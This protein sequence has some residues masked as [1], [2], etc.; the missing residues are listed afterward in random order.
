MSSQCQTF[1]FK[2]L[3]PEKLLHFCS[4]YSL[5]NAVLCKPCFIYL[6]RQSQPCNSYPCVSVALVLYHGAQGHRKKSFPTLQCE[7]QSSPQG[8]T[9]GSWVSLTK[10]LQTIDSSH[11]PARVQAG[12]QE[13]RKKFL[14]NQWFVFAIFL[15]KGWDACPTGSSPGSSGVTTGMLMVVSVLGPFLAL[16]TFLSL[17][18]DLCSPPLPLGDSKE[19]TWSGTKW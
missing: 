2:K 14:E 11:R 9:G 13:G 1:C 18:L 4:C 10:Y 6:L 17:L 15:L 7:A 5:M 12:L 3:C 16:S 8:Q 19:V